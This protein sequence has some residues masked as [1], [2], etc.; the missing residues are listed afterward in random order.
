MEEL[1]SAR[2]QKD[3]GHPVKYMRPTP[4]TS[5]IKLT[6]DGNLA[7]NGNRVQQPIKIKVSMVVNIDGKVTIN[8]KLCATGP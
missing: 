4:G 2:S 5:C 3:V 6:I 8:G 7:I 1:L